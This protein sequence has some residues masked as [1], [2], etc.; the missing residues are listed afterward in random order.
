MNSTA[1]RKFVV[2]KCLNI[3]RGVQGCGWGF[4]WREYWGVNLVIETEGQAIYS[5]II[6]FEL[7]H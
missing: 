4:P 1:V 6:A 3:I 2:S 5:E 7:L